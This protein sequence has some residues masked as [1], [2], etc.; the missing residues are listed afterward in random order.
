VSDI[1]ND[2]GAH[3]VTSFKALTTTTLTL[4]TLFKTWH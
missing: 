1:G 4:D 3:P 2:I